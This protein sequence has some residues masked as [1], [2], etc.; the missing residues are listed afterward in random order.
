MTQPQ[1]RAWTRPAHP[2]SGNYQISAVSHVTHGACSL[3]T[4][5]TA[6]N[7]D[8]TLHCNKLFLSSI[9]SNIK[10]TTLMM[11][12]LDFHLSRILEKQGDVM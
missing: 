8:Q 3:V 1:A 9:R 2:V 11:F 4:L 5:K 6:N 12:P 7:A 10:G